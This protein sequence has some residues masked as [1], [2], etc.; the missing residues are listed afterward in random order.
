MKRNPPV[1]PFD[2]SRHIGTIFEIGPTS[3]KVALSDRGSESAE[4]GEFV[5][6]E[7]GEWVL[8]GRVTGVQSDR[9]VTNQSASSYGS[10]APSKAAIELLATAAAD[11]ESAARGTARSPHLG[12]A[13]YM[14]TPQLLEWLFRCSQVREIG[15]D[16]TDPVMLN[17]LSL[18]D[19]ATVGLAPERVFGRHCAV[20][21]AT[22]VGK[23]WTLARLIEESVRY[24]AKVILFDPTGEFHTLQSGARHL[25]IGSD[26]TG[27]EPS[28][29][30]AIPFNALTEAD[31]F[32]LFKPSGPTQAPK[33]R[34]A[35]KSLKLANAPHL[36]T[37]GVV[38]KAGRLKFPY[39]AAYMAR[40]DQVEDPRANFDISKLPAQID[41]ECVFPTGG[42]SSNPDQS[43]WGA[44]NE[45]ERSN[46]V[47]LITRIEEM[48]H[49]PELACVFRPG[50][51]KAIFEEIEA[52]IGDNAARV[53]R[54]SLQYLPTAH[55]AREIVANAIGRH[56][57]RLAR[58]GK[59]QNRPL[60]V[61]LD[62][63]HNFLNRSLGD[64]NTMYQLD[65]FEM[66]AKEG[67]KLSLNFCIAT[68]RP[69]DIPEGILSQIGTFI[70]HRLNN[71]MD[72]EAVESASS[73]ADHSV[74]AFV[75]GLREGQAIIIG[76]D[77]PIPLA[78]QI[79]EPAQK[80]DSRG[81]DYQTHWR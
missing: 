66:I 55:N 68:Q 43:R 5:V 56:T 8:F 19:D 40:A 15:E 25:H 13:V 24:S 17:L 62:E 60:V 81:P 67:R 36:A 33:L 27:Q 30:A 1:N 18:S 21:G 64:E 72:R 71:N 16:G 41:A 20:L 74:M 53:L 80:P 77:L 75:P 14:A 28:D 63:A 78:V 2:S 69:R 49:A 32:A 57:L 11:G 23:S 34:A 65:S 52:F 31:L 79:N 44:A 76:A 4:V 10:V 26:P 51:T 46:C 70:V 35:I 39:E 58:A 37:G 3:A 50:K 47:S 73:G 6:V 61:F 22:G 42:F 7:R 48:M 9:H 54:I 29:E 12:S 59:L 45:I 38:I